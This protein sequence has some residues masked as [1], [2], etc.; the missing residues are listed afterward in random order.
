MDG[1]RFYTRQKAVLQ[2]W[3]GSSRPGA[4]FVMPMAK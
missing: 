3:P 2:G 1:V 4:E